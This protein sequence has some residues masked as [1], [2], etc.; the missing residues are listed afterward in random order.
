MTLQTLKTD[1]LEYCE[2]E[3]GLSQL[4][5]RNYDFYLS[6]FLDWSKVQKPEEILS[7]T[8]RHYRLRLNRYQNKQG[9]SLS[10]VT[11]NYHLI[12]LRAFLKYLLST[13][14]NT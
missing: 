7:D 3:K 5:I 9:R 8:I 13:G 11:Q 6:R 12:A 1:F 2:I 4:T 14:V 10:R